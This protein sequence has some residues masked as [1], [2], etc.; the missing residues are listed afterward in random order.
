MK[1]IS[2]LLV[3][4]SL[5]FLTSCETTREITLNENG[6]GTMVTT[7]DMSS[8]IGIAKMSGQG[9]KMEDERAID[10][11]IALDKMV[12]SIQNITQAEK[13]LLKTGKLN[14]NMDMA[15]DKLLT[16]LT[17]PFANTQ[18]LAQLN[19]LS[20]KVTTQALGKQMGD[21]GGEEGMP[22][23]MGDMKSGMD[24]YFITTYTKGVIERKLDKDK[25]A[26]VDSD[27]GMQTLKKAGD[28]GLPIL[29]NLVFKL[30]KPAKKAEGKN[31]T[32]SEDKKTV[33]IKGSLE[34]FFDDATKMEFR[35]EY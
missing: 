5:F 10:T 6:S 20:Q 35:I 30:P 11:V 28:E 17:F 22:P 34:D 24:D 3:V 12:D 27:Q 18:Q 1:R 21:G 32:L 14:L 19:A 2:L 4:A 23:G 16:K 8:L 15:N 26:K 33:T 13:D 29:T 7:T 25:Y 31:V 9:D